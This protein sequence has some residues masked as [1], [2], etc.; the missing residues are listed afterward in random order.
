[1]ISVEAT[2]QKSGVAHLA[3]YGRSFPNKTDRSSK[4]TS[5]AIHLLLFPFLEQFAGAGLDVFEANVAQPVGT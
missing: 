2:P 5:G 3:R 1:M 4:E